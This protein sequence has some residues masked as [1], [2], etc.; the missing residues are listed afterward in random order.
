MFTDMRMDIQIDAS[1][2]RY[3]HK[4]YI[5]HVHTYVHTLYI[6]ID[7]EA[8]INMKALWYDGLSQ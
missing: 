6:Y 5:I 4:T 7:R 2:D 3:V 1:I 8:D